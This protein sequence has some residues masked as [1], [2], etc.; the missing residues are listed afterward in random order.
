MPDCSNI[1]VVDYGRPRK[2][3]FAECVEYHSQAASSSLRSPSITELERKGIL[4]T[5]R[6]ESYE[7]RVANANSRSM[8]DD[9][10]V[11]SISSSSSSKSTPS[12]LSWFKALI[13]SKLH[14]SD[15]SVDESYSKRRRESKKL[16]SLFTTSKHDPQPSSPTLEDALRKSLDLIFF[17]NRCSMCRGSQYI[18][19]ISCSFCNGT[20]Y[21]DKAQRD[22]HTRTSSLKRKLSIW[23]KPES[24]SQ[25]P[26]PPLDPGPAS[27]WM[28]ELIPITTG[29]N[30]L[31]WAFVSDKLGLMYN[32][33]ETVD[34]FELANKYGS[35]MD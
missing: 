15:Q 3:S 30:E 23:S 18:G 2:V 4:P 31:E 26:H 12:M 10:I 13:K 22:I 27:I 6:N 29:S 17:G 28:T 14:R 25:T 11:V 34:I 35:V 7:Q 24:I 20:G 21:S 16:F 5:P 9:E 1:G 32:D 19:R 8:N 33:L